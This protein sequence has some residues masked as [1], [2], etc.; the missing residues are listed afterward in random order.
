MSTGISPHAGSRADEMRPSGSWATQQT[1]LLFT[2]GYAGQVVN[3]VVSLGIALVCGARAP[4]WVVASWLAVHL[5][6]TAWRAL[7]VARFR[8]AEPDDAAMPTWHRRFV[9]GTIAAGATLGSAAWVLGPYGG[10]EQHASMALFLGGMCLGAVSVLGAAFELYVVYV[11]LLCAPMAAFFLSVGTEIHLWMALLDCVYIGAMIATGR[12]QY[13]TLQRM[14]SLTA[15]NRALEEHQQRLREFADLGADLF[16]ECDRRGRFSYLTEGYE[17][18]TGRPTAIA[19]GTDVD[20][21]DRPSFLPA[22]TL[23]AL[24]GGSNECAA[25][26]E[27]VIDWSP[28]EGSRSVLL[29]NA[30]P[31]HDA[32]GTVTGYRGTV[33]DVTEQHRLAE[34]LQHQ[35]THDPLTDLA[36]RREFERRLATVLDGARVDGSRHAVCFLDLDQF[37]AVN[38]TCGHAAGDVLL[39]RIAA[40]VTR[41]LRS[42][43]T[44]ARL[45]GDEFG[46]LLEHCP[47]DKATAIAQSIREAVRGIDFR[48]GDDHFTVTVSIGLVGIDATSGDVDDVLR[49]ADAACY[50]AKQAGRDR[51]QS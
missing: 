32:H 34:Q 14:N 22:A 41:G 8:R 33:R 9:R 39:R 44:L 5:A 11:L 3:V 51:V 1:H 23:A 21:D 37:K 36:N 18:L 7:Q 29:S 20:G 42:R 13:R 6:V 4:R 31:I 10:F 50:A 49:K 28:R 47:L 24:R 30:I 12:G 27:H 38:D 16:W 19:L 43:D 46:L 26:H 48:W 17:R 2:H 25:V 40:E 35:A 15:T 45:G